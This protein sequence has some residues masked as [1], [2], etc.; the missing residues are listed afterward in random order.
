MN[1]YSADLRS[2]VVG[3]V[4]AGMAQ[5]EAAQVLGVGRATVAQRP[6]RAELI[7]DHPHE[8]ALRAQPLRSSRVSTTGVSE[9]AVG[10]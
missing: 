4:A 8:L 5:T 9:Q 6:A 1:V 3:A 2:R 10:S 7:G